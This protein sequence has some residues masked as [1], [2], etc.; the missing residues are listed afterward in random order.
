MSWHPAGGLT[1]RP[2]TLPA[3]LRLN[4]TQRYYLKGERCY[5]PHPPPPDNL[6]SYKYHTRVPQHVNLHVNSNLIQFL[7]MS[8]NMLYSFGRLMGSRPCSLTSGIHKGTF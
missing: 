4:L 7:R 1:V 6:V 2:H 5:Y 8:E 3:S